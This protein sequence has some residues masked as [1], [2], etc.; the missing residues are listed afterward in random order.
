MTGVEACGDEHGLALWL[1]PDAIRQ[2]FADGAGDPTE[3][4]TDDQLREVGYEVLDG[5]YDEYRRLLDVTLAE[6]TEG[7]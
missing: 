5:I 4:L 3:N 1:T 6:Y 7:E 2:A